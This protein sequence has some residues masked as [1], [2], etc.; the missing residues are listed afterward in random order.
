MY[1][2]VIRPLFFSFDPEK[3]HYFTFS[4]I[5]FFHKIG[6]GSIFRSIYKIESPKLER[7]LFG[8][9]F[10]NPVGLAAGFDKD[11]K[12]YKELSNFGF[13][14]IEIGTVTPKPQPGNDKPRLFRLKE[15]AAIINR[16]GFNN[17]GVK[18]TVERLK[19]N[20]K[21]LIGGNIGKNKTTPN[22]EAVKDY[23][24]C[25]EALFDYVNYFV[26]NVS[27]PNTPNLRALQEKKPLTDLLKTLQD[28]N[29]L[30]EKRK[31]I[32]LKI[33]PDLTDEQLLDII[34]IVETTKIDGVIATNTT[35]S[36]EGI[37]SESKMEMGGLSGKPLAKRATEVIRFLSEKS[38]KAFPIIGVG[39]IHS[40]ED[41]LEKLDAGAS[42]VQLY[43]GF[44]Y[45]GPGLIKQINKAILKRK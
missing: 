43:T 30:K 42:L 26:V 45:E 23:I 11:A 3:I 35:I 10:S 31:P 1:K 29:N 9:K 24:I 33:A 14:F 17:G 40:A 36:R 27:S 32:L 5:R 13:G 34:E 20:E 2:S 22:E 44:I 37:S 4:L 15:D 38:N 7:E 41:A 19:G 8:L 6:F 18:E 28:R 25:F 39:G 21:V 16:M 12:L